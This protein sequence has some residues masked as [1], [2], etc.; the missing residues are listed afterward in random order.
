MPWRVG[1]ISL[2]LLA[3]LVPV[4][5]AAVDAAY[6]HGFYAWLQPV[7]TTVSNLFPFALLDALLL[8]ALVWLGLAA[9]DLIHGRRT[10][11]LKTVAQIF[12]RTL[13]WCAAL[14]LMFAVTWGFNYRRVRL[15]D[16]L[17]TRADAVTADAALAMA[18][19]AVDEMNGSHRAAHDA[20]WGSPSAIDPELA[21]GLERAARDVAA[22]RR[23]TVG[24]P[25]RSLL[26]WYFR[27]TAVSGMTNPWALEVVVASDV[28]PFERPMVHAHEW[29]HLAGIA[30]EGDANFVAWLACVRGSVPARYSAWLFMY[31]EL[32]PSVAPGD[33]GAVAARLG[34]GPRED[35]R[36]VR[37]RFLQNVNPRLFAAGWTVYDSYLKA[38][39]VESGAASYAEVVRLALG[40]RYTGDWTPVR[41]AM[42]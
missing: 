13:V 17:E 10:G 39:R 25:K 42:P 41:R 8:V 12:L 16:K 36:A 27:R 33:R 32:L 35:L 14:Y 15:V 31:Q 2:A 24:R 23:V 3:A 5:A 21:G 9:R 7:L 1:L 22:A 18:N 40:V 26:D 38:N 29:S 4:P 30:H 28:L 11:W 20:G 37:E 34:P 6:S 19:R